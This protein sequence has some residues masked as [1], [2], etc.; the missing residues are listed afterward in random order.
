MKRA[1]LVILVL[2]VLLMGMLPVFASAE[3]YGSEPT[4]TFAVQQQPAQKPQPSTTSKVLWLIVVGPSVLIGLGAVIAIRVW[5][6]RVW[7]EYLQDKF[8]DGD[9]EEY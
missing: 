3:E 8:G 9:E 5:K 6:H 7:L 1:F 2:L 4:E